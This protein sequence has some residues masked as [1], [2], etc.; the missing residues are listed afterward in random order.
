MCKWKST[1]LEIVCLIFTV[2]M[3]LLKKGRKRREEEADR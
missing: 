1:L 2:G 3:S